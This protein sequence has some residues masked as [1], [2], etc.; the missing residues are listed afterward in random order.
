[1]ITNI[2]LGL[3]LGVVISS[4]II[5]NNKLFK[6]T[7][8]LSTITSILN[9]EN[10]SVTTTLELFKKLLERFTEQVKVDNEHYDNV[11]TL[12]K[13]RFK[14]IDNA[15]DSI[16]DR[17]NTFDVDTQHLIVAEHR[18]T[19]SEI[20]K[21]AKISSKITSKTKTSKSINK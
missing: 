21:Q 18:I 17:I 6:I 7:N 12:L 15:T 2:L 4:F 3:I 1:M 14:D 8:I 20:K 5:L 9:N 19:R 10:A 11:I 13:S 16:Y